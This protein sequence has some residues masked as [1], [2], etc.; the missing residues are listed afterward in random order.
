MRYVPFDQRTPDSQYRDLLARILDEG[1]PTPTRQGPSAL[2]L[3]QQTMRFPLANGF[4]VITERSIASFWRKPIGEL[5]AFING[6]TTLEDL[7]EFGCDWWTPGRP[8]RRRA[9]A[10]CHRATSAPAPTVARSTTSRPVRVRGSTSSLISSSRSVSYPATGPTSCRRGS[11]S[12]RSAAP[13]RRRGRRSPRATAGC[14]SVSSMDG[15][16]CTCSS[17]R[18]TC[19]SVCR[20]TWCSTRRSP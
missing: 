2:T 1:E 14:T 8:R 12:T 18:V 17:G 6:A 4:P 16:T 11:R 10:A 9:G 7:R 5:C 20:R 19:R 13:A 3:I 15:C